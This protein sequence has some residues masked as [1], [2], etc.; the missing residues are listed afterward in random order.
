MANNS[1]NIQDSSLASDSSI[2]EVSRASNANTPEEINDAGGSSS[3]AHT[4]G[5]DAGN[6]PS[7]VTAAVLKPSDPVP[8]GAQKVEGIEFNKL[9]G[10]DITVSELIEGMTNMGFQA[11][12]VGNAVRIINDMVGFSNISSFTELETY[13][14]QALMAG[15]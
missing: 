1:S 9:A 5:I 8:S 6:A 7:S 12:A 4:N 14:L 15:S 11:T 3:S 2:T 13:L 10:K